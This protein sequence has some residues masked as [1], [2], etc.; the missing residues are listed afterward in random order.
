ME[1][2]GARQQKGTRESVHGTWYV[3]L[4]EGGA[5]L[6]RRVNE[7]KRDALSAGDQQRLITAE[8]QLENTQTGCVSQHWSEGHAWRRLNGTDPTT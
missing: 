5:V 7:D 8:Q 6:R 4:D 3:G 1:Q 2:C